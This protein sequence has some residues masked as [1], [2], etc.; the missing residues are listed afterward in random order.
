MRGD[1]VGPLHSGPFLD[2]VP[3]VPATR[4]GCLR[5]VRLAWSR[6]VGRSAQDILHVLGKINRFSGK[7]ILGTSA[8]GFRL[9]DRFLGDGHFQ[10]RLGRLLGVHPLSGFAQLWFCRAG[11][12]GP[13][14]ARILRRARCAESIGIPIH[15]NGFRLGDSCRLVPERSFLSSFFRSGWPVH[16]ISTTWLR[17]FGRA[18][19]T[20]RPQ[21]LPGHFRRLPIHV[22][23]IGFRNPRRVVP[24]RS[25]LLLEF[26]R[27]PL[28]LDGQPVHKHRALFGNSGRS[29]P[30]RAVMRGL[31]RIDPGWRFGVGPI[32]VNRRHLD[33][34]GRR[35][36]AMLVESAIEPLGWAVY[37][38]FGWGPVHEGRG[39]LANFRRRIPSGRPPRMQRILSNGLLQRWPVHERLIGMNHSRR[40]VPARMTGGNRSSIPRH[41]GSCGAPIHEDGEGQFDLW[42]SVPSMRP[43]LAPFSASLWFF[44]GTGI[45]RR[46]RQMSFVVA[47]LVLDPH[48]HL[49]GCFQERLRARMVPV[50]FLL[51]GLWIHV[52]VIRGIC[53]NLTPNTRLL[54]KCSSAVIMNCA[55]R[56]TVDRKMA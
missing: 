32:Q 19:P 5:P 13:V 24:G 31:E 11:F 18:V 37:R 56:A 41:Q 6:L 44:F 46:R 15:Q 17:N 3:S 47:R 25:I 40:R 30:A 27:T 35:V 8:I 43:R 1:P 2:D 9:P 53:F 12:G 14:P 23:R 26:T 51:C 21:R 39:G 48:R 55:S 28:R 29:V 4:V 20:D 50:G 38:W 54:A 42:R 33:N 7:A 16:E 10:A 34:S 49:C 45:V 36:P 22:N 52:T